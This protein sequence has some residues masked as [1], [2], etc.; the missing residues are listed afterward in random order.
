M[1]PW[2]M[3]SVVTTPSS[4][5]RVAD[6]QPS[7]TFVIS[8][9]TQAEP[10]DISHLG[11]SPGG[12]VIGGCDLDGLGEVVGN[13]HML[14]VDPSADACGNGSSQ[15]PFNAIQEAKA[16]YRTG[17]QSNR[18][19]H[20]VV[21]ELADG[22]YTLNQ[23][24]ALN[25]GDSGTASQ[26]VTYRSATSRGAILTSSRDVTERLQPVTPNTYTDNLVD[27]SVVSKLKM[28]DLSTLSLPSS[29]YTQAPSHGFALIQ[30]RSYGP[31]MLYQGS[32]RMQLAR[33]PNPTDEYPNYLS[34]L[35]PTD[36]PGNVSYSD[37]IDRGYQ[38]GFANDPKH[39]SKTSTEFATGGGTFE[40]AYGDRVA[41]WNKPSEIYLDGV[42]GRA[43][44]WTYNRVSEINGNQV[45]L[46]RGE[47]S[48]I[49]DRKPAHFY[50]DNVAE[51]LDQPGEFT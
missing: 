41:K 38:S 22:T 18:F 2:S 4:Y 31:A 34:P 12:V 13:E 45:T 27:Q 44:E 42:V 49:Y 20:P 28:V 37:V 26:P 8:Q 30:G 46:S 39:T 40:V 35:S 36:Y 51:E 33:W 48:G 6:S 21:I 19:S 15:Y 43:W 1:V 17:K 25:S 24:L 9:W 32:R 50:C 11:A 5:R 10:N 7:L 29:V 23:S 3:L 47:I 14:Y 16:A